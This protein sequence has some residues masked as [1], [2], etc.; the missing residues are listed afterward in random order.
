MV[1]SIKSYRIL[2]KICSLVIILGSCGIREG[3]LAQIIPDA[4]LGNESSIINSNTNLKGNSIDVI[5]GGANRGVNLFHSFRQFNINEGE[6]IYFANPQGIDNIFSRI[7]GNIPSEIFGTLGVLGN[8]NLYLLNPKGIIFGDR[9]Q[10]DIPGSFLATTAE[11]FT[12]DNGLEFSA[13]NPQAAPLLTINV[14][15][16]LKYG[17][18]ASSIASSGNLVVGKNL[19]LDSS[20]LFLQGQIYAGE[21]LTLQAQELVNI[22][23]SLELPFIAASGKNLLIQGN[24]LYIDALN[25]SNS[26]LFSAEELA[27]SSFKP[28]DPSTPSLIGNAHYWSGGNFLVE[29]LDKTPGGL[30]SIFPIQIIAGKNVKLGNYIGSSLQILAGG[31]VDVGVIYIADIFNTNSQSLA[32]DLS[33]GNSINIDANK[34][35]LD[36]RADISLNKLKTVLLD[37]YQNNVGFQG[38][39]FI[40]NALAKI[41]PPLVGRNA[42]IELGD[43]IINPVIIGREGFIFLSNQYESSLLESDNKNINVGNINQQEIGIFSSSIVI[44]SADKVNILGILKSSAINLQGVPDEDPGFVG[45]GQD[46]I[47]LAKNDIIFY[48]NTGILAN[49]ISGGNV[50]IKTNGDLILQ[51]ASINTS[52]RQ[53]QILSNQ[54]DAG[55]I[56]INANSVFLTNGASLNA[57]TLGSGNS[58]KIVINAENIVKLDGERSNNNPSSI[59]SQVEIGSTGNSGGIEITTGTLF[60]TNGAA[61]DARTLGSGNSGKIVINAENIVKLDG[62]R[63]DENPSS[64]SSQVEIGSTGN[65]GGIEI[66]TGTLFVTNGA[67]LDARTLGEGNAGKIKII[68]TDSVVFD[69]RGSSASSQV[70]ETGFGNAGGIEI[71]TKELNINNGAVVNASTLGIGES[72]EIEIIANNFDLKNGGKI[73]SQTSQNN[74]AGDIIIR[75]AKNLNLI[76]NTSGL[77][78]NT[79]LF[80]QGNGGN[81]FIDALSLSISDRAAIQVNSQGNGK[82]GGIEINSDFLNLDRYSKISADTISNQGGNITLKIKDILSLFDNSSISTNAG[83]NLN[84]GNG[85]NIN[86]EANFIIAKNNSDITANAFQG[87]GGNLKIATQN[88]FGIEARD[89]LTPRSDLTASSEFGSEGTIAINTLDTNITQGLIELPT[90]FKNKKLLESC[91]RDNKIQPNSSFINT[92]RSG[93]PLNPEQIDIINFWEDFRDPNLLDLV[94]IPTKKFLNFSE[95]ETENILDARAWKVDSQGQIILVLQSSLSIPQ[96]FAPANL[97]CF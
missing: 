86:I 11:S 37:K 45:N 32:I 14:T 73:L 5:E 96:N 38:L 23:D 95:L 66:T 67:A 63:S 71:N 6:R 80:S 56:K 44:D 35:Y 21:N 64:V 30:D 22:T 16:G 9:A 2:S 42:S 54:G 26:I 94:N 12:F 27:L 33:D 83:N 43:I 85:G 82:G 75:L 79:E 51:G 20:N 31:G 24:F 69:G 28:I 47:I 15:P 57:R 74:N 81:I 34:S 88:L 29:Y 7:T 77:F 55:S 3:I 4:T 97:F 25:N 50:T 48:E 13:I 62:K 91:E 17:V 41:E 92:R 59:S 10:L 36:I 93:L 1:D 19:T 78:A 40:K 8:A 52:N 89:R 70:E 18:E 61:L 46:V 58:G 65:S 90:E 60:V 87:N 72:G 68:A 49:G 53:I 84:G 39:D 76:G